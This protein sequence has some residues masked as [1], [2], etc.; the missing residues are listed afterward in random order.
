[1]TLLNLPIE[2][3]TCA[4]CVARVERALAAVPGVAAAS[5]NLATERAR[6][7]LATGPAAADVSATTAALVDAVAR[8]GYAVPRTTTDLAVDGMTCAS[9]VGRIERALR[10][11]PGVLEA[12]VNLATSRARV[13]HAGTDVAPLLAAVRAAGYDAQ[14]A[15]DPARP[16][17]SAD[18]GWR[19]ALALLLSAPLA[20]PMVG[21]LFGRHWMLGAA[22]QFALAAPV[23]FW[24]GARFYR[25]GWKALRARSANMDLLVALGTSAAFGL[26]LVL[27][28]RDPTGMPHLYFESAAV[29]VSLVLLGKWLEARARRRTLAALEALRALAPPT[30]TVRRGGALVSVPVETLAVGDEVVVRPGERVPT[31]GTLIEGRSHFDESL[32]TGESLPVAR[33]PG[34]AVTGGAI[35]GEGLVVLRVTAVG[36]ETLLARIVRM[37]EDAQARKPAIQKTVDR[38][39]EVFVPAVL[40]LAAVTLLGWGLA[41]GDWEAALV[42]AVSVLVIACPCA[43][44]LAT[45]T[46]LM[47]GTGL[48]AQ[49]GILVRDAQAL[50]TM[51]QVRVVA[52]DKTGTLTLGRPRLVALAVAP[53]DDELRALADA[54]ALQAGSE[55]PLAR[56][57]V[58]AAATRGVGADPAAGLS[59]VAGR[60]IE[61]QV[62]GRVLR[63]GSTRWLAEQGLA[64]DA[65]LE[66]AAQAARAQGHSVSWLFDAGADGGNGAARAGRGVRAMLAF[67]DTLRPEAT[68]A[69]AALHAQGVRCVLVSGDHRAA[70]EAVAKQLGIDEVHAEVLPGDK[71][72]VVGALRQGL[73]AGARVAMVGDGI[74]DAPALAA[75][76]VGLA[77]AT[78]TDV[79]MASAGLTLMRGDLRLVPEALALS[80]AVARKIGQ[81]LFWAFAYNVVGIPAAA[82]GGLTPVIAGAAMALSSVTVVGNALLLRRW[83][84][85]A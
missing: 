69:V 61:G 1:L 48:A 24:L 56:A 8:A 2:G 76:D 41:A 15:T 39:A 82:L 5:V 72:Q 52:F 80:R 47:V 19:V 65:T 12:E 31:D 51:R 58:D 50:E 67:G 30:A 22:W 28:W 62:G 53:G 44:G 23:Q 66:A 49:R 18:P 40:A 75:A 16:R 42:H 20:L 59:A 14:A 38:V 37:V 32:L 71:A 25:A 63:L 7:E 10:A 17:A 33:E 26:S 11:V 35:N 6:V 78:G 13:V 83:K 81:N 84:P 4:S 73:P 36:T 55:H 54:G 68:Q 64:P 21:D 43:L 29:V 46:A 74:N 3:M 60:G 70:A 79:A 85:S 9:C 57:V 77:L 27:W 34:D 45:P